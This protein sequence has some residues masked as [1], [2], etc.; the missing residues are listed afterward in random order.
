MLGDLGKEIII[1]QAIRKPIQTRMMC[2]VHNVQCAQNTDVATDEGFFLTNGLF[3]LKYEPTP[4]YK[5]KKFDF[6][7]RADFL[8]LGK[9]RLASWR[10]LN[11]CAKVYPEMAWLLKWTDISERTFEIAKKNINLGIPVC[12][13]AVAYADAVGSDFFRP[14]SVRALEAKHY[15][16]G[17]FDKRYANHLH[18]GA[19]K[20]LGGD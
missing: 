3:V 5:Y 19:Q 10:Q 15:T 8:Y 9:M 11:E 20:P 12:F 14:G 2:S 17:H 18:Y 1:E 13:D 16:V 6:V 4:A 7:L